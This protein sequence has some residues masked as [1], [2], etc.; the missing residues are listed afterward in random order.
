MEKQLIMRGKNGYGEL[1]EHLLSH[2]CKRLMLVCGGSLSGTAAGA[3]FSALTKRTGIEVVRFGGFSPNPDYD[4]IAVGVRAFRESGCDAVC[5]AGGGSAMDTAKCIKL[6]AE[7]SD[8]T[9]YVEQP[10]VPNSVPLIAVPTT[11]GS[12]SEATRFAVIYRGGVKLSVASG[13]CLP[14]AVLLDPDALVTLPDRHR[15]AAML[16]ALCHAIESLW[17]VSS[18]DESRGYS[19]E[20]IRMIMA[21]MEGYSA[22]DSSCSAAMMEAAHL[23]GR[24]IN[25]TT[26]T[27]AH[28]MCYKLT[29]LYGLPHGHAAALCLPEV[30][31]FLCENC[32]T[33]QLRGVLGEIPLLLGCDGFDTALALLRELPRRLCTDSVPQATDVEL[34]LLA[35]SVNPQRLSNTPVVPD[36]DAINE[37]YIHILGRR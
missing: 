1:E 30:Y 12:G 15:C 9:P 13:S 26:T 32:A 29:T 6:F 7:M 17:S 16:D 5:G 18:T 10:I 36:R 3:F 19:R 23:A 21:N 2:G 33:A 34:G 22:R 28:A 8:E 37:M 25:I 27:A 31:R 20:A 24:A 4:D 35:D 14:A 11:A